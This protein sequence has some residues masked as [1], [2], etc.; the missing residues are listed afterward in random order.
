M[1]TNPPSVATDSAAT[2]TRSSW[3]RSVNANVLREVA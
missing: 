3:L 2:G 1:I